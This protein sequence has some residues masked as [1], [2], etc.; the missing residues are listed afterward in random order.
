MG[1]HFRY[2][3]NCAR[4]ENS[5][6]SLPRF[7]LIHVLRVHFAYYM[8]VCVVVEDLCCQT[9]IW[10][11]LPNFDLIWFFYLKFNLKFAQ[12]KNS[13]VTVEQNLVVS[14][15]KKSSNKQVMQ[16]KLNFARKIV[17][18]QCRNRKGGRGNFKLIMVQSSHR[19]GLTTASPTG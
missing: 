13:N 2:T 18:C 8:Y 1:K 14:W 4:H 16:R 11:F 6:T 19:F 17:P 5:F 10:S 9:L 3:L 12:T 7:Q 15:K